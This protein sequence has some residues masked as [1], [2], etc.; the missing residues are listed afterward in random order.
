MRKMLCWAMACICIMSCISM[1]VGA[2]DISISASSNASE[3]TMITRA[4]GTF[5]ITVGANK[6]TASDTAFPL[7][8]GETVRIRANYSPEDAS[9]DFG[10]IDEE[11]IFHYINVT[12]GSIDATIRVSDTGNY[13]L[14]IRNNSDYTIK[15]TGIATY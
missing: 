4:S 8:A 13:T 5:T 7:A 12:T 14:A 9:V 2:V 3:E 10:L 1:N 6:R 11:G 15:V